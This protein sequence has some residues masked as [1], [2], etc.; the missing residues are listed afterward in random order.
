MLRAE[1]EAH[2]Q[3]LI[4]FK[5]SELSLLSLAKKRSRKRNVFMTLKEYIQGFTETSRLHFYSDDLMPTNYIKILS[6]GFM[7]IET[8]RK[9]TNKGCMQQVSLMREI[10]EIP[11]SAPQ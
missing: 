6:Y 4:I 1:L 5:T 10:F 11:V 2:H 7:C 8:S 9:V 3:I